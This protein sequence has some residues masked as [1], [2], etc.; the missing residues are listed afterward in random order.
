MS[1]VFPLWFI[2][3]PYAVVVLLFIGIAFFNIFN[4]VRYD[5]TNHTSFMATFFF[6]AGAT[7][8]FFLTWQELKGVDWKHPVDLGAPLA[9]LQTPAPL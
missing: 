3:I 2:L 1:I 5:A 6:F 8:V 7:L 9:S 4:L